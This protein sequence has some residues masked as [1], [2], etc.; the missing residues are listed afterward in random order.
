VF[1]KFV[2]LLF[3]PGQKTCFSKDAKGTMVREPKGQDLFFCINALNPEE[4]TCPTEKYHRAGR[5]RRA[6]GNVVC[7]RNFLVEIDTMPVEQQMHYVKNRLP[8]TTA[9]YSGGKS[10]T[11]QLAGM[12]LDVGKMV[13]SPTRTYAP[14][15]LPILEKLRGHI[16][17]LIHCS[18]GAQT[19]VLNFIE[20]LEVVKDNLFP[21]PPLF[22]L[23]QEESQTPWHEM[24][25]VFNM[26]HRL[27]VYLPEAFAQDVIDIAEDFGIEARIV[28]RVG[29]CRQ[30]K[31]TIEGEHGM[32][33]YY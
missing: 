6:D 2:D 12:P 21:C 17:G 20:G 29:T 7:Y 4:D 5:P 3:D 15:M 31:V 23:I 19:K 11:D 1:K 26:G 25:K 10:L 18:G 24:Y 8:F 28:G 32:F 13:L 33:V 16:H 9:V 27:E 30:K 22:E 14:V